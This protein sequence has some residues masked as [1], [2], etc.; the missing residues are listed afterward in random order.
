MNIPK[1]RTRMFSFPDF[2]RIELAFFYLFSQAYQRRLCYHFRHS[3]IV[4]LIHF[5]SL[6]YFIAGS[7]LNINDGRPH[8][9]RGS[10]CT[11]SIVKIR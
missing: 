8:V 2:I 7:T 1:E 5:I 6:F 4:K 9:S 10:L 11:P 3:T